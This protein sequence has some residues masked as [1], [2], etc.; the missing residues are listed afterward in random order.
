MEGFLRISTETPFNYAA[1]RKYVSTIQFSSF[2]V[3][4]GY[5]VVIFSIKA[6][7]ANRKAFEIVTPLRLWNLWLAVFSIAGSAVTSV[8]LVQEINKHGIVS[9]YTKA[10]DFFEG[11]SGLWT[12][13]FCMSKLAE[14]GDT[15]FIVLRKKPLMF[16]HWYHHVATLN[17]GL[18]SYVDKSAYNTW[19]VWLNFSVHAVMYSYYFLAACGIRLP[20]CCLL[21][22]ISYVVLFGNFFYHAY[23][24]GGGKKFQKEKKAPAQKTE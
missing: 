6:I 7:M 12:F 16:L 13:L 20:A 11:T 3:T 17:Y 14:L 15:I 2:L 19:I 8:A 9:S 23:I 10:Q 5:V 18:M 1:A 22:E 24:K 21:M 4:I